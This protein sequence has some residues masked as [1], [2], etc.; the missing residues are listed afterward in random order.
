MIKERLEINYIHIF[1]FSSFSLSLP[2]FVL[3]IE[4]SVYHACNFAVVVVE[5]D[6]EKHR[7]YDR[8]V[9]HKYKK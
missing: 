9:R 1:I 7:R 3:F 5:A 6:I 4:Q 2:H 8:L